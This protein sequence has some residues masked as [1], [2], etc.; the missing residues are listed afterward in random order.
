MCPSSDSEPIIFLG[1][2]AETPACRSSTVHTP[3]EAAAII[4]TAARL[5]LAQGILFA[6]PVPEAADQLP[7]Q[8]L[9]T[10][11]N[12]AVA[13]AESQDIRGKRLT[14]FLLARVSQLSRGGSQKANIAPFSR[15]PA[16]PA[17]SPRRWAFRGRAN[18]PG[19]PR[20]FA[21]SPQERPPRLTPSLRPGAEALS[22]PPRSVVRR[23]RPTLVCF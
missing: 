15:M 1:S 10:T 17:R 9:E 19:E 21:S 2:I 7:P 12:Q 18:R 14:P 22:A 3:G 6:V 23:T 11:V 5:G 20:L 13:E 16:P 4:A 8:E